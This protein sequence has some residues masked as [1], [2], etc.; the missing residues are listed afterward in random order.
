MTTRFTWATALLGMAL[1]T[2]LCISLPA[3]AAEGAVEQV[4]VKAV[5]H[6]GLNRATLDPRDRD[7]ILADV[8]KLKG[9]TWQTVTATGHTD[10]TG[11]TA[12]N[13][14]LSAKR[15]QAVKSYLVKK[16]L[17]ADMIR[18]Q[19]KASAAP[20]ADNDSDAGRAQNRRTEIEFRGVRS[21]G[22]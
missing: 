8:G 6:F 13:T 1:A 14:R 15:A 7:T 2:P 4:E 3:F 10:A 18:T 9:V 22:N 11:S 17:G 21:T 12:Y 16:G 20:V 19:A 5:A